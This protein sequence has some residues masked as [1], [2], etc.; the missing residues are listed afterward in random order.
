MHDI[1]KLFLWAGRDDPEGNGRPRLKPLPRPKMVLVA[2]AGPSVWK[3]AQWSWTGT[4]ITSELPALCSGPADPHAHSHPGHPSLLQLC[5]GRRGRGAPTL[6]SIQPLSL[7]LS[8]SELLAL[9]E[10]PG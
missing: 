8:L 3:W 7:S 1:L 2:E 9:P 4:P 10:G 5:S 6:L